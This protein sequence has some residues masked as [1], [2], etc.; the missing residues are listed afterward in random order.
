MLK[1]TVHQGMAAPFSDALETERLAV[2]AVFG[3]ADYAEG[4]AA[5]AEKRLPKF[6]R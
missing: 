2:K 4:L 5:F 1:K 6:R 3:S